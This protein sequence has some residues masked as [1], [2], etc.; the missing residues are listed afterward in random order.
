MTVT[1]EHHNRF[2]DTTVTLAPIGVV[3][4]EMLSDTMTVTL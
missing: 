2:S 1:L 4:D 3:L